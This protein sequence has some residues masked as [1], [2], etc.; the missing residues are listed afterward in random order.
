MKK[1]GNKNVTLVYLLPALELGTLCLRVQQ[2]INSATSHI[3]LS[4]NCHFSWDSIAYS[5]FFF[6]V[7]LSLI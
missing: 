4:H 3:S 5:Q 2:F 6:F 7:F 1:R